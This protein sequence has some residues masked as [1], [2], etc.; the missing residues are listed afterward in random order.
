LG[1][2]VTGIEQTKIAYSLILKSFKERDD[3]DILV[4]NGRMVMRGIWIAVTQVTARCCDFVNT[5][6]N[7]RVS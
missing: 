4:A 1:I 7:L 3:S 6:K 2:Y 5:V